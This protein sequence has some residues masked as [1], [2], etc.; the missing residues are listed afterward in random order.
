MNAHSFVKVVMT[1]SIAAAASLG[2]FVPG[3]LLWLFLPV[4][5]ND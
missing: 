3:V 2:V 4:K 5:F 1:A